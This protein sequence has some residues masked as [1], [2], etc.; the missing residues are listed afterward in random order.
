MRDPSTARWDDSPRPLWYLAGVGGC[1]L[2]GEFIVYFVRQQHGRSPEEIGSIYEVVL[3]AIL[4]VLC[5]LAARQTIGTKHA[6]PLIA[7]V[8]IAGGSYLSNLVLAALDLLWVPALIPSDLPTNEFIRIDLEEATIA[9]LCLV[10]VLLV[11]S[12]TAVGVSRSMSF[13]RTRRAELG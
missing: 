4:A 8:T 7:T 5:L 2:A 12:L 6:G 11:V 10:G 9:S 13:L 1:N 3:A